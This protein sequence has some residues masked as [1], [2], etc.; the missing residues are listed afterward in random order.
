MKHPEVPSFSHR[1]FKWFCKETLFEELE[2][3]LEE[4]FLKNK[5]R[6]GIRKARRIYMAEV[7]RMLRPTILKRSRSGP[8]YSIALV[9]NYSLIA[10]RNLSKNKLFSTINIIGL[11]MSMAIGLLA[12]AFTSEMYAYDEFHEKG[13]RI[14]RLTSAKRDIDETSA[15]EYSSSSLFAAQRLE[16]DFGGFE[17]IVPMYKGFYGDITVEEKLFQIEGLFA[18]EDFFDV[19]TFPL[20]YGDAS[21]VLSEPFSVVVSEDLAIKLFNK[22]NVIGEVITKDDHQYTITGVAENPPR[23]S[24]IQFDALASIETLRS[25][26][27][28]DFHYQWGTMWVSYTYILLPEGFNMD[29]VMKNLS[30]L[31]SEE[32]AKVDR[33]EIALGLESLK[34]IF[35]GDQKYN[36]LR[37]VMR[38]KT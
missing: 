2:G 4:S 28:Y 12:I 3:D 14:Y 13:D 23:S 24:H 17:K 26:P 18:G 30:Q 7:L 35:P 21:S 27:D 33:F 25:L 38:K 19:F 6:Y 34:S 36:Q 20:I 10:F 16:D 1:L 31:S 15:V 29:Q 32:N 8:A 9:A 37:T 22:K 11:A 5:E